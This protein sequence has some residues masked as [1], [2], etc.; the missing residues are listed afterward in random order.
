[1]ARRK[2]GN[3]VRPLRRPPEGLNGIVLP[4]EAPLA[5]LNDETDFP[6]DMM[7]DEER[8]AIAADER[9]REAG[10]DL[11]PPGPSHVQHARVRKT[12]RRRSTRPEDNDV[13]APFPPLHGSDDED[14]ET[15][16]PAPTDDELR[17]VWLRAQRMTQSEL[18]LRLGLYLIGTDDICGNVTVALRGREVSRSNAPKFPL[19]LFLRDRGAQRVDTPSL[20]SD[21]RGEYCVRDRRFNLCLSSD[22]VVADLEVEVGAGDRFL[23]FGA[24]GMLEATRSP[25]EDRVVNEVIGRALRHRNVNARD[26][27]AVALPRSAAFRR[28]A[29]SLEGA[30]RIVSNGLSMLL[31]DRAGHVSGLPFLKSF[32]NQ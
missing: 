7:S 24:G 30:P 2:P 25:A 3:P 13:Y 29:T 22:P 17:E 20:S 16:A 11:R 8:R 9:R 6:D 4:P 1:M 18:L 26:L 28:I 14:E 27:I 32:E 19:R 21:W 23:V 31:V 5:Y 12:K 10:L 15:T